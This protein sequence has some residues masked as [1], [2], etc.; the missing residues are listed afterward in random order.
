MSAR[1][2]WVDKGRVI[3][4]GNPTAADLARLR[5]DGFSVGFCFLGRDETRQFDTH[6]A[7]DAGWSLYDIPIA[8]GD[9]P[10]VH[11]VEMFVSDISQAPTDTMVLVFCES[12]LGR[13]A[14]MGVAYWISKGLAADKAIQLI[15]DS[16]GDSVWQTERRLSVLREYARVIESGRC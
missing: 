4:S 13:S 8:E 15:T 12:G 16:C 10:T 3:A 9:A 5:S 1:M 14:C 7:A 6:A 11:Q 2:W